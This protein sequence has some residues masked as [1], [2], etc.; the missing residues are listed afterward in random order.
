[1]SG[2]L[3]IGT[4]LRAAAAM[5]LIPPMLDVVPLTRLARWLG[6]VRSP[7]SRDLDEPALARWVDQ[8]LSD[9]PRPWRR[10]CLKRAA[11]LYYLLRR[12]GRPVHLH[13]GVRKGSAGELQAHAWLV[14]D[15]VPILEPDQSEHRGFAVIAAFPEPG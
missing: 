12:S 1:M 7:Q 6:A 8:R 13:I 2:P 15:G 14:R 11:V 4:R 3:R 10:T 9:L 5:A